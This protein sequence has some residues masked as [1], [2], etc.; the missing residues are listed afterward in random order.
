MIH[1]RKLKQW[2]IYIIFIATEKE[3]GKGSSCVGEIHS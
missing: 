2:H 3:K 1:L